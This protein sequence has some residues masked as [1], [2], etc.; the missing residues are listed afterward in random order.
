MHF[1]HFGIGLYVDKVWLGRKKIY[2]SSQRIN[3]V[4]RQPYRFFNLDIFISSIDVDNIHINVGVY[5]LQVQKSTYMWL[6]LYKTRSKPH[7]LIF[8]TKHISSIEHWRLELAIIQKLKIQLIINENNNVPLYNSGLRGLKTSST[9]ILLAMSWGAYLG[10]S[11][12]LVH[13]F[14]A[15]M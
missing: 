4:A 10:D 13:L 1:F 7:I 6:D 3:K 11:L 12:A 9:G 2:F 5:E 8:H 15:I 14:G